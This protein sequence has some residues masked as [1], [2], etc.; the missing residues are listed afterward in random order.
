MTAPKIQATKERVQNL[1]DE[2][3]DFEDLSVEEVPENMIVYGGTAVGKSRFYLNIPFNYLEQKIDLDKRFRMFVICPDRRGGVQKVAKRIHVPEKLRSYIKVKY[4]DSYEELV[5]AT[6]T[7]KE[8]LD[9]F[10]KE[11]K[12]LLWLV[13]ELLDEAWMLSQDYYTRKTYGKTKAL[14]FAGKVEVIKDMVSN[15]KKATA[16]QAFSG[17]S[18]WV[19]IKSL[20]NENWIDKIKKFPYNVLYTAEQK[21]ADTGTIFAPPGPGVRPAGEKDNMHRVDTII[22]LTRNGHKYYQQC[23]KLTGY[24]KGYGNKDV[25]NKNNY[26]VHLGEVKN[27]DDIDSKDVKEETPKKESNPPE[28]KKEKEVQPKEKQEEPKKDPPKEEETKEEDDGF[29]FSM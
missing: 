9:N 1:W 18:D 20:H 27:I 4:V 24:S 11:G 13:I 7:A 3:V 16:F 29:D 25:T 23:L 5:A 8:H 14:Y 2:R 26:T 19:V 6:A 17:F 22:Y 21:E 12:D 15:E 10:A 28:E